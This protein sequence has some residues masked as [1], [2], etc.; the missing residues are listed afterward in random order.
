MFFGTPEIALPVLAAT[1]ARHE[2]TAVV[3]Q[4]DRPRGRGKKMLPP[5]VKEW[6]LEH[7]LPVVQP[8]KLNDGEF[9]AWLRAQQPD[10]CVVAAYGRLLKAPLLAIPPHGHVNMHPSLL[11]RWRGP[12]PIQSAL[13]AGD[14]ETGVSIM[15]LVLEMD[16][17][18]IL[19]QE[20]TAIGP[21][22]D[23]VALSA[24]LAETGG[25]MMV[26]A[27]AM[28]EAGTATYTPQSE[29]GVTHA[30]IFSKE[31]GYIQWNR[32]AQELHNLVRGATPWPAAQ[33]LLGGQVC[34]ILL[35]E[36]DDAPAAGAPGVVTAVD[37][38]SVTVATGNGGLRILTFQAPGKRA[39]PMGDF[40][41]GQSLP[42]GTTFE[43]LIPH[44]EKS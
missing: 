42:V 29:A 10:V 8:A 38:S 11:P 18:D 16:A 19:L 35:A 4:P 27:L 1:A 28:I 21:N 22:E 44:E 14:T 39:M 7:A 30:K 26:D 43:S 34:K 6:A 20:S 9:E 25:R 37:K 3:C 12:S 17:G 15:R 41:R 24:R 13:L 40:L 23:A 5:P 33:C 31:D 36:V 32:P 2:V